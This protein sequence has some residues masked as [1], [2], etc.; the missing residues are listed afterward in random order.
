M[1]L[2]L[3]IFK[4]LD[5]GS[6]IWVRNVHTR[7]QA[8]REMASLLRS[9]PARYFVRDAETG[10]VYQLTLDWVFRRRLTGLGEQPI[11]CQATGRIL[12]VKRSSLATACL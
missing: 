10:A 7:A 12:F 3:D 1:K 6:P 2:G 4:Q 9:V 11:V 8:H 5:D